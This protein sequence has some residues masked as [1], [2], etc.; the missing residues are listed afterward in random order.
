[1]DTSANSPG[2]RCDMASQTSDT[3]FSSALPSPSRAQDC[4]PGPRGKRQRAQ[5]RPPN[6]ASFIHPTPPTKKFTFPAREQALV[7]VNPPLSQPRGLPGLPD[8]G[9]LVAAELPDPSPAWDSLNDT[10][11]IDWYRASPL[12]FA[13]KQRRGIIES[14]PSSAGPVNFLNHALSAAFPLAEH[15]PLPFDFMEAVDFVSAGP[16]ST[17]H[18]F[19]ES[20]LAHLER[21]ARQFQPDTDRWYNT[22]PDFI[23]PATGHLHVALCAQL[24][25]FLDLSATPWLSQFVTGFPIVGV[26]SQCSTS[27][28]DPNTPTTAPDP[29]LL[30]Q[31]APDRF[32]ARARR[33][34]VKFASDLWDEA[35]EQVAAG[36][37]TPPALLNAMGRFAHDPDTPCNIAFRFG[38]PQDGKLRGCE[39]LK[40]SGTNA[41]CV[42]RSPITLCGWDHIAEAAHLFRSRPQA[43]A[44]GK[45]D[46]RAAYKFLP[47]RPSDSTLA[48]IALWNPDDENWYGCQSRTQLFGSTAS[49]LHYN[50]FPRLLTTFLTR[51]LMLPILGYFDDFG[52]FTL[53]DSAETTLGHV[54][55][56]C[57]ILCITLKEEKS[58][59]GPIMTF[60]GLTGTFPCPSNDM[61]LS[62]CLDDGKTQRW[63]RSIRDILA[64]R[65]ISHASLEALIGRLNF[66]QTNTFNR[67]ARGM[68]KPLYGKLYSKRY[69]PAL[70]TTSV[71]VLTWWHATLTLLPP[72]LVGKRKTRPDYVLFTDAS[73]EPSPLRAVL[74]GLLFSVP[75]ASPFGGAEILLFRDATVEDV[76]HF[77]DTSCIF[78]IEL[79]TVVST[80]LVL[81]Q[82]LTSRSVTVYV[83]NNAALCALVAGDSSSPVAA[84]LV[85]LL[86]HLA[87]VYDINLWFE[88]VSSGANIA[89][90]PTRDKPLPFPILEERPLTSVEYCLGYFR[91]KMQVILDPAPLTTPLCPPGSQFF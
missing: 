78:G 9:L 68:L 54:T 14:A 91:Q 44:F 57:R 81:R 22:A 3:L 75:P 37:L 84:K 58:A 1:M 82:R 5:S 55:R 13:G 61:V 4:T 25:E 8:L 73:Y 69:I 35:M 41:M 79:A 2:G 59:V 63:T 39:D 43:W 67:F 70:S 65:S 18:S 29:A 56:F 72:R 48:V 26:V 27:P 60:L 86:W 62:V 32:V 30:F 33:S 28:L 23:R 52:F 45:V 6:D 19:R 74:A 20:Q 50:C 53:R 49:V 24:A 88:R 17:V 64:A 80:I 51:L 71:R 77:A 34:P 42:V 36:W 38:V 31:S 83:D 40:D 16:P 12:S 21:L 66:A 10:L 11:D 46:H 47:L 89:D 85:G 76:E 15:T 90:Y 87:A 7:P